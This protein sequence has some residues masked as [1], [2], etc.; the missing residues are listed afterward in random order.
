[1]A[2]AVARPMM[3]SLALPL[4]LKAALSPSSNDLRASQNH[5]T[6]KTDPDTDQDSTRHSPVTSALRFVNVPLYTDPDSCTRAAHSFAYAPEVRRFADM[7]G[8][9]EACATQ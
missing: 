2:A 3:L 6:E 8:D 9:S 1:M 7:K 4:Q 5:V